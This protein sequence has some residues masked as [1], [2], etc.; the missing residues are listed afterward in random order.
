VLQERHSC[1][2][3]AQL[4]KGNLPFAVGTM[5]LLMIITVGYLPI[6]LPLLLPEV[7][8]NPATIARSLILLMLFP[9]GVGLL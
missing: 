3:L 5:V 9:L 2:K 6:V 1:P 8:V 7:A 4:S